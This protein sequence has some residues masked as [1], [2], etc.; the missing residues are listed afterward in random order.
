MNNN[1]DE[2]QVRSVPL[3]GGSHEFSKKQNVFFR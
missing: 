1:N 3:D 2:N